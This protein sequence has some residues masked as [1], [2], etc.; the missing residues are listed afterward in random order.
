MQAQDLTK[1]IALLPLI[2]DA[3]AIEQEIAGGG[4][5]DASKA[6]DVIAKLAADVPKVFAT[7]GASPAVVAALG[8]TALYEN[9]YGVVEAVKTALPAL[10]AL[11]S[12]LEHKAPAEPAQTA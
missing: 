9:V 8:N 1:V 11:V 7:L 3:F 10:E 6:E 4:L 12:R 5:D 2:P